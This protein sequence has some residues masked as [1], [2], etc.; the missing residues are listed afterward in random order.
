M[1]MTPVQRPEFMEGVEDGEEGEEGSAGNF[2]W[3]V[4]IL[5][6]LAMRTPEAVCG[7]LSSMGCIDPQ[8]S[9]NVLVKEGTRRV[10]DQDGVEDWKISF[11]F[12]FQV[13]VS[14]FQFRCLYEMMAS[15]ISNC[16]VLPGMQDLAFFLGLVSLQQYEKSCQPSHVT[17]DLKK[18]ALCRLFMMETPHKGVANGSIICGSMSP[19]AGMDLH[20][21]QNAQQGLA[22]LGSRKTGAECGNRL[23]GMMI[24]DTNICAGHWLATGKMR[25]WIKDYCTLSHPLLIMT[26]ASVVAPGPRCIALRGM[27]S[28]N[29]FPWETTGSRCDGMGMVRVQGTDSNLHGGGTSS[30][31][32]AKHSASS[33]HGLKEDSS[34]SSCMKRMQEVESKAASTYSCLGQLMQQVPAESGSMRPSATVR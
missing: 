12:V 34:V 5:R 15:F 18:A 20:P 21:R 29:P 7:I 25:A 27:H 28:W 30:I 10:V 17:G 1:G 16:Q 3:K 23:V 14:L 11:H 2:P 26:E 33:S 6:N 8:S 9:V 4:G 22:C 31:Q 24:V 13:A 19:L 32:S